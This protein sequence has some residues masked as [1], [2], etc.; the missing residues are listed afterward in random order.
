MNHLDLRTWTLFV[1][2]VKN[3][4]GNHQAEKYK[5]LVEKQLKS[6]QGI[7]TNMSI[8]VYFFT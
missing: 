8:K 3:F 6:L 7:G 5:K 2:V 1:D 4:L